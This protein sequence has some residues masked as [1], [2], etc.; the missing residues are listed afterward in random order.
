[1]IPL[2]DSNGNQ[3]R[4][5]NGY[6]IAATILYQ[7]VSQAVLSTVAEGQFPWVEWLPWVIVVQDNNGN[8][9]ID[10]NK[11]FVTSNAPYG[12]VGQVS[13]GDYWYG[14]YQNGAHIIAS[15]GPPNQAPQ[16]LAVPNVVGET[17]ASARSAL[18]AVNLGVSGFTWVASS[19]AGGVVIS[20]LPVAGSPVLPGTP[21]YLALSLGAS[22]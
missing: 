15:P 6:P 5:A 12:A 9:V 17:I 3:V 8:P 4:D 13:P 11:N 19:Q 21:V 22:P 16:A 18:A 1:M 14:S 2:R 10:S 20:Q 7:M